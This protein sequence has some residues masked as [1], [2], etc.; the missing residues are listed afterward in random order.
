[1]A[2]TG[3]DTTSRSRASTMAISGD[4]MGR[5]EDERV[6]LRFSFFWSEV[7]LGKNG[8]LFKA[9]LSLTGIESGG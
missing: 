2:E 8:L 9:P 3:T 4:G 7:L 6:D 1:M 5:K